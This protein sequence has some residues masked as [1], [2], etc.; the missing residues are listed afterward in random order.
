MLFSSKW[1]KFQED[2]SGHKNIEYPGVY[3][4]AYAK[5]NLAGKKV[6]VKDVFYIGMSNSRGGVEQRIYQFTNS[7]DGGGGHS[8]GSRFLENYCNKKSYYEL[9]RSKS[10]Y[11]TYVAIPCEV[12]KGI[13]KAHDLKLMGDVAKLEYCALAHVK[14]ITGSEP[15]LNK[16]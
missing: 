6:R 8:A 5:E 13:R 4:F 10:L 16:K 15:E 14:E 12:R 1:H 2:I 9:K 11:F 7:I 3:M